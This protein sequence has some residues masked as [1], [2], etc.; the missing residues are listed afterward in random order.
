MKSLLV[1]IG[2]YILGFFLTASCASLFDS[3]NAE[4]S[5]YY[6]IVFSIL[7]LCATVSVCASLILNELKKDRVTN[8]QHSDNEK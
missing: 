1:G 2:I 6:A 8:T 7:Y 5:Y 4:Y 3:G